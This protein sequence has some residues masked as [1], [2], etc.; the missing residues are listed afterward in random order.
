M[1]T[2]NK[3]KF[4]FIGNDNFT[5]QF[6][7]RESLER[8]FNQLIEQKDASIDHWFKNEE[9]DLNDHLK[10]RFLIVRTHK[11]VFSFLGDDNLYVLA[12]RTRKPQKPIKQFGKIKNKI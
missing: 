11:Y 8:F 2:I 10:N 3:V 9:T 12:I 5:H 7:K 6:K 1:K 4:H